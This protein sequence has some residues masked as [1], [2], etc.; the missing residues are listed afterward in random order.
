MQCD[1]LH[2]HILNPHLRKTIALIKIFPL[3]LK[4]V[5]ESR[6]YVS[7]DFPIFEEKSTLFFVEKKKE[8]P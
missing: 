2:V 3:L 6:R 1:K 8:Y 5:K 4:Y 7:K